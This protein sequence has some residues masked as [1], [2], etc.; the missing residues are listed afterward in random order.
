MWTD[1]IVEIIFP[2]NGNRVI[3]VIVTSGNWGHGWVTTMISDYIVT[4]ITLGTIVAFV[5]TF[6]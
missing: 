5:I 1:V 4:T 6:K 2:N 3:V